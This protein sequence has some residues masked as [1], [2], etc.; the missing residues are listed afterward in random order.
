M[1]KKNVYRRQFVIVMD[2]AERAEQSSFN[3]AQR[4]IL[5]LH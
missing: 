3:A 1:V 4:E 2:E 5:C